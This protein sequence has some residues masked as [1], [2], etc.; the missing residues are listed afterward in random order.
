MLWKDQHE[1]YGAQNVSK[2]IPFLEL[3]NATPLQL[4]ELH[5]LLLNYFLRCL[6]LQRM[7]QTQQ[8]EAECKTHATGPFYIISQ[9]KKYGLE[10]VTC[11]SKRRAWIIHMTQDVKPTHQVSVFVVRASTAVP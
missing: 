9:V 6:H 11:A 5:K 1:Q 10:Y 4:F 7:L 2:T 8:Y 3:Y